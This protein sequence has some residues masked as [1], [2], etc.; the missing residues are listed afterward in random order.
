MKKYRNLLIIV[1]V[2]GASVWWYHQHSS[3]TPLVSAPYPEVEYV[4]YN[5]SEVCTPQEVVVGS[6]SDFAL[7]VK[8]NSNLR[9]YQMVSKKGEK[10]NLITERE[11][12]FVVD[13]K[14]LTAGNCLAMT[15]SEEVSYKELVT[16][17]Q[18]ECTS[19]YRQNDKRELKT[20]CGF[21]TQDKF[22]FLKK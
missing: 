9:F 4:P 11:E 5:A 3:D 8:G 13:Q 19:I 22:F 6:V 21:V 18:M 16:K 14:F 15:S 12:P 20:E 2:L 10:F 7:S 17:D 1:L